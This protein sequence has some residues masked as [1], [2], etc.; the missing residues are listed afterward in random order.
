MKKNTSG[1]TIVELL[2]VIVVIAVLA[3]ISIV[4][5][6]GIQNRTAVSRSLS[7]LS[8]LNKIIQVYYATN[9]SYPTTAN[10][11][12]NSN[13][14][15]TNYIP[16][17]TSDFIN[18]LPKPQYPGSSQGGAYMYRSNGTDYK[19]IAHGGKYA[20]LCPLAKAQQPSLISNRDCWAYGYFSSGAAAF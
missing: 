11:W 9:G 17:V 4:A 19:I 5:Y 10:A 16:D 15:P 3:A 8:S 1:F 14:N 7:D 18:S 12:L 20:E 6:N 2:I 13:D